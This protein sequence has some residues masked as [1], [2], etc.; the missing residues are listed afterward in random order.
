MTDERQ[1]T[2]I[3]SK[4]EALVVMR[5]LERMQTAFQ[6]HQPEQS[7]DYACQTQR[8]LELIETALFKLGCIEAQSG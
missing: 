1:F 7:E 3:F 2:I 5:A 4:S 6:K 8:T